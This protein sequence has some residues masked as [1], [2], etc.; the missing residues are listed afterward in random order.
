MYA[1]ESHFAR[2][3]K[4]AENGSHVMTSQKLSKTTSC[5]LQWSRDFCDVTR[6]SYLFIAFLSFYV[7]V[8]EYMYWIHKRLIVQKINNFL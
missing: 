8:C 5:I 3:F 4:I 2:L 1:L 6:G 7:Y